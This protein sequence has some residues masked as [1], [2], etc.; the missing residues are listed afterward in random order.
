MPRSQAVTS[1]LGVAIATTASLP[2]ITKSS[3]SSLL[4]SAPLPSVAPFVP[5]QTTS[6]SFTSNHQRKRKSNQKPATKSQEQSEIDFLKLELNSVRTHVIELETDK[7]DL[8][9][10]INVM[11]EVIKMHQQRQTSQTFVN[12]FPHLAK[13]PNTRQQPP[14]GCQCHHGSHHLPSYHACGVSN[15]KCCFFPNCC[16]QTGQT[17]FS[18]FNDP[19]NDLMSVVKNMQDE[20]V[21]IVNKIDKITANDDKSNEQSEPRDK[22]FF[23]NPNEIPDFDRIDVVVEAEVHAVDQDDDSI[24]SC[25][26]FVPDVDLDQ[27]SS[28]SQT[29]SLN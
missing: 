16:C 20:I 18:A 19:H 14:V 2:N 28:P 27:V 5:S 17:S 11:N 13:P 25:D 6:F 24:V 10:K 7:A 15:N 21:D 1:S 12:D 9:R 29:I 23:R 4:G 22:P 8:E 3:D 26:E